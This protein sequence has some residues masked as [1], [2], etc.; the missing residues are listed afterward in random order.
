MAGKRRASRS[1]LANAERFTEPHNDSRQMQF[2]L[3]LNFRTQRFSKSWGR[4]V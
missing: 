3:K 1:R 4:L 2:G